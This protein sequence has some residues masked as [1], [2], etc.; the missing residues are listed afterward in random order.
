MQETICK[1]K[2]S[3]IE[4]LKADGIPDPYKYIKFY[5]LRAHALLE[6][7]HTPVSEI[8]YIHAKLMI[9]DDTYIILGSANVNDRS[10]L[11]SRDHEIGIFIS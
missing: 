8:I 4:L 1:G 10:M 2:P 3:L 5:S 11:G 7:L 9:V 6:E